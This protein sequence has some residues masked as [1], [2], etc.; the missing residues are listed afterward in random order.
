MGLSFQPSWIFRSET[1]RL[2]FKFN[3]LFQPKLSSNFG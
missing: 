1:A 3:N 2:G